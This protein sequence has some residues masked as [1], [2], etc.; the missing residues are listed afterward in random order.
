[1]TLNGMNARL[2]LVGCTSEFLPG[3][4]FVG[5]EPEFKDLISKKL[6]K[7]SDYHLGEW[8]K[9]WVKLWRPLK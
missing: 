6:G 4:V 3:N 8:C 1:M 2:R 9:E 5:G 7:L